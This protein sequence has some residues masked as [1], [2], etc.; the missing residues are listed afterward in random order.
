MS[1]AKKWYN[2]EALLGAL[3]LFAPPL[4]LYGVYK[5]QSI[6]SVFKNVIYAAFIVV[7]LLFVIQFAF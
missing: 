7:I 6:K 2:N 1:E 5:N 4:G 3:L